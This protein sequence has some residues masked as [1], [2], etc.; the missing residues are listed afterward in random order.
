MKIIALFNISFEH[1]IK[2]D[3]FVRDSILRLRICFLGGS[4][5]SFEICKWPEA[6]DQYSPDRNEWKTRKRSDVVYTDKKS[7]AFPPIIVE[8]Q[9]GVN[10]NFIHRLTGYC[11]NTTAKHWAKPITVVFCI[12]HTTRE[13]L[14][15]FLRSKN[16]YYV[17]ALEMTTVH[18]ICMLFRIVKKLSDTNVSAMDTLSND[19]GNVCEESTAY[20]KEILEAHKNDGID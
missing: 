15:Y 7:K 8:I 9:N 12:Q 6:I 18:T 4:D 14:H 16:K 19:Y 2:A 17:I 13:L 11:L 3:M 10:E 20:L 5:I 1:N